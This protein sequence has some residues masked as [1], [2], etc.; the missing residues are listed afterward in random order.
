MMASMMFTRVFQL[1]EDPEILS[2]DELEE[3]VD[4]ADKDFDDTLDE[5]EFEYLLDL[6]VQDAADSD[7]DMSSMM[8]RMN[9][10]EM[11]TGDI[12]EDD[13]VRAQP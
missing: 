3:C 4:A 10:F 7:N 12:D 9:P 13:D 1:D 2:L 8:S 5:E 11:L 6:A